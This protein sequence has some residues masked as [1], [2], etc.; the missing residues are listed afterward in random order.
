MNPVV[1]S[2]A[3]QAAALALIIATYFYF[4]IFAEFA[5][6]ERMRSVVPA[7]GLRMVMA[8]LAAGGV[9]GAMGMAAVFR[10]GRAQALLAWT[11]RACAVGA[12]LALVANDVPQSILI[13]FGC[14]GA[15]G[16]LTV[17]VASVL[18]DAIGPRRL[19]LV[20]GLGTG[21]AYALSNVPW[22]FRASPTV[23][24]GLAALSVFTA[25]FGVRYLVVT[26]QADRVDKTFSKATLARWT[27]V[28]LALV[29]LDS[30]AFYIIQHSAALRSETWE[31]TRMLWLNAAVHLMGAIVAGVW[32]DRGWRML[33]IGVA[34]VALSLG[35]LALGGWLPAWLVPSACY[36][37][38]VSFYS[39]ALVEIPARSG[40]P[41]VAALLFSISGWIG[42]ALGI[43][44]AQDLSHIPV[45]FIGATLT[46]VGVALLWRRRHLAG[47]A[48]AVV[49]CT[50]SGRADEIQAGREVYIAE[51]C[52]HCHSQYVRAQVPTEV[53][54]WGPATPLE[55]GLAA[56]PPLFGTRRQG[57]DLARVGNRRSPEWNRLHLISPRAISPGSR[58]PSY[59]H[60]FARGDQRGDALLAYL[61]SLGSDTY[62][63]RQKQIAT[64]QP[65]RRETMTPASSAA[66][67]G[68][69]CAQ[70]H[71]AAGRG[72]GPMAPLLS[73]KP[74]NWNTDPWRHVL[75]G[76]DG[77]IAVGRII[78]FGLPG[79]PMAGHEYLSDAEI[80]GLAR[81][82]WTLHRT[83]KG[84]SLTAVP[85]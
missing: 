6:L 64:W 5:F 10:R 28:L 39:V 82:V 14:G 41:W 81:H 44:M 12:G 85:P 26:A 18:R 54:N 73:I 68:Q 8:A 36:T 75:G 9:A 65:S 30:A 37:A 43:G 62:P 16:A 3:S 58:M 22:L 24:G 50:G 32:L 83:D 27:I 45:T 71:G 72:D 20:L 21:L 31:E 63:Q 48:C 29:W 40:R 80:L 53:L 23:Q 67:F 66:L 47:L 49:M 78:K 70:C 33:V 51:G 69:L 15:L 34:V 4:L 77:E 25:S 13:A 60:L 61:A 52:I 35:G 84:A 74:P 2:R 76:E 17:A 7:S 19:G 38:G 11:L 55:D 46:T 56:A 1:P 59:A 57:P 42:S 79:L